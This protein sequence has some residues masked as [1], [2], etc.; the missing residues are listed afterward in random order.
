MTKLFAA[1][2]TV[3]VIEELEAVML[4]K[5]CLL[6]EPLCTL[7][8]K[9]LVPGTRLEKVTVAVGVF[10]VTGSGL[11]FISTF[12]KAGVTATKRKAVNRIS[13]VMVD[14]SSDINFS[15]ALP[16]RLAK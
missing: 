6:P 15:L 4:P 1:P 14:L 9:Y 8:K 16:K 7:V 10:S 12:A 13:L 5:D 11:T 2:Q 3:R